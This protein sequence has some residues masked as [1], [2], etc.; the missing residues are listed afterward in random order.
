V[1]VFIAR[2]RVEAMMLRELKLENVFVFEPLQDKGGGPRCEG[3][4]VCG[5]PA[6]LSPQQYE[7]YIDWFDTEIRT[8][9]R[10]GAPLIGWTP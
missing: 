2:S 3:I 7:K 1:I 8:M 9:L 5:A 10:P 4:V 6:G